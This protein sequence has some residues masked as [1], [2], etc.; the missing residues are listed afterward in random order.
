MG[1]EEF[2][3]K[4]TSIPESEPLFN[5]IKSRVIKIEKIK[6]KD[7]RKYWRELKEENRIPAIYLPIK[8]LNA[9]IE[10]KVKHGG[11]EK[12]KKN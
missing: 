11:I 9:E 4:L 12:W 7:E 8:E 10:N 2:G 6:D 5:V 3:M 1:Y